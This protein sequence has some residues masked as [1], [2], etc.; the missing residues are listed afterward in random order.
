MQLFVAALVVDCGSG[1]FLPGLLA[2]CSSR[3]LPFGCRQAQDARRLGRYGPEGQF[4][5]SGMFLGGL[6]GEDA[7][8]AVFSAV[9]VMLKMLGV[10]VGM[11]HKD[12]YTARLRPRL[13]STTAVIYSTLVLLVTI[14]LVLRSLV[15][16]QAR[17]ARHHVW[18][19][20]C[21]ARRQP[22]Q[23]HG[24]GWFRW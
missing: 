4:N 14:H 20:P 5:C 24:H 19:L 21:R 11:D 9:V 15:G 12:S 6:F 16:R 7:S 23:W 17:D 2:L 22:R 13:S 8:H 3:C 18:F 10:L 1:M